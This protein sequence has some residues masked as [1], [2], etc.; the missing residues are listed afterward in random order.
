MKAHRN[1][2]KFQ[3]Q[4]KYLTKNQN[5]IAVQYQKE[6]R[7]MI[8]NNKITKDKNQMMLKILK[9]MMIFNWKTQLML[10]KKL[11]MRII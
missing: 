5:K 10:K 1:K 2:N 11:F 4:T 7:K 8:V 9:L 3:K 6:M